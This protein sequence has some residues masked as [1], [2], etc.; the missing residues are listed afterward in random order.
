MPACFYLDPRHPSLNTSAIWYLKFASEIM[1]LLCLRQF[2]GPSSNSDNSKSIMTKVY[3]A[4]KDMSHLLYPPL[5]LLSE[6]FWFG[7]TD[8]PDGSLAYSAWN[9]LCPDTHMACSH[10][11]LTKWLLLSDAFSNL[12]ILN[13]TPS[14]VYIH[15]LVLF[16]VL[17]SSYHLS[18]FSIQHNSAF[19]SLFAP[20]H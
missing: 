3:K 5:N 12:F 6:S 14:H 18:F 15:N 8:F 16:P 10:F 13:G 9:A 2:G 11:V 7:H 17:F 4:L 19:C 1:S 20:L